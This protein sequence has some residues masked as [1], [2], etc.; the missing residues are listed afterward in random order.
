MYQ[1]QRNIIR[2]SLKITL[3]IYANNRLGIGSTQMHP[4][5]V[6]LD[7]EPIFRIDRL[8]FILLFDLLENGLYIDAIVK[9]DLILLLFNNTNP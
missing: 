1:P 7:L 9:L 2:R 3:G 6:K 4:V 5:A 8:I